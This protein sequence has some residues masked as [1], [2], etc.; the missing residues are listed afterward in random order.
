MVMLSAIE[1]PAL[2]L[3]RSSAV[4]PAFVLKGIDPRDLAG[5]CGK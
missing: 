5:R 4:R 1:D 3:P 2:V